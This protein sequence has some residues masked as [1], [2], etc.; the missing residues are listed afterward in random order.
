MP[1]H[2]SVSAVSPTGRWE[3]GGEQHRLSTRVISAPM[4]HGA[5]GEPGV[6]VLREAPKLATRTRP[7]QRPAIA[8]PAFALPRT[9]LKKGDP[10]QYHDLIHETAA[11]YGVDPDLVEA[12]VQV[13][14]GYNPDAVSSAGAMGMMQLM[15]ATARALGV[16]DP[17]DPVQNID[18]GVRYLKALLD[19]YGGDLVKA[20]AAY[21]AGSGA[22][23]HYGGVPPF[24]ETQLYVQSV[25]GLARQEG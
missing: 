6:E 4:L 7:A 8:R 18:G 15:P 21:N 24:A 10:G 11:R 19:R 23:D 13:E 5:P 25:L 17:F 2:A 14:S 1:S 12:V 20:L 9:N 22:V 3:A 16:Q